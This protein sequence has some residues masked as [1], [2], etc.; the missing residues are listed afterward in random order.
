MRIGVNA[1]YLIP[2][3]VGGTE[4]Y[5]RALLAALAEIDSVNEYFIFTNRE[6]GADLVP[7]QANFYH[8]PQG[9]RAVNRVARLLWEQ[10][11]LPLAARRLRIDVLFNPG[12]TSPIFCGRPQV[13]VFHDLQHKRHPEYFRWFDLP[14]WNFFLYWSARVA[15]IVLAD[16]NATAIDL[17]RFYGLRG[18]RVR[19]VPLGV[20][21]EFLALAARR[22]PE[23]FILGVST[24][25]PHKNLNGLLRAF[26]I[27]RKARPEYRLIVCGIHGFF[28][29]QLR[30]LREELGLCDSVDFPGWIPKADLHEL[31]AHAMAFVYPS[32][33]EGFGLPVL[34]ALAA[35][36]PSACSRVEPVDSLAGDAALKFDPNDPA[37]MAACIERLVS[38]AALRARLAEAG[39]ARAAQFTWRTTAQLT[40]AAL[41]QAG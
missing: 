40:L 21:P 3:G 6:T 10:T 33:F 36:V 35:G 41:T 7:K 29:E 28:T 8:E 24:L 27:F 16:S 15:R 14:A 18:E 19:I 2:G 12:F 34:E 5:L 17:E 11:L 38:D 32:R 37:E 25:H 26:A 30:A 4:T 9:V 22:Q 23:P 13:T 31:Y 20:A 39:P 1:L